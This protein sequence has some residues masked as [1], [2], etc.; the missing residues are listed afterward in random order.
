MI[1]NVIQSQFLVV[2]DYPAAAAL[3]FVLMVV[4]PDRASVRYARA[5][6]ARGALRGG[7]GMRTPRRP[8]CA[9]LRLLGRLGGARAA[10]PVPP[11][12]RGRPVL[13]QRQQGPLQLHLAGLHARPLEG[14]VRRPGLGVG[15]HKSLSI[16]AISTL[17]A[18]TLGH[19]H[20]ARARALRFRGRGGVERARLPAARD[21]RGRARRRAARAVPDAR[22]SRRAS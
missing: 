3:S 2:R 1:G 16:A 7:G 12:L 22:S 10:L 13:V 6:G 18:L 20:G 15:V 19:V 21:A 4:R 11:D 17:I 14:S 8:C 5:L 9:R